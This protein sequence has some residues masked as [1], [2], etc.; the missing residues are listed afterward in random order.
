MG[1]H[2]KSRWWYWAVLVAGLAIALAVHFGR[3]AES[4]G[5]PA[6]LAELLQLSPDRLSQVPLG[7]M[8]L[9]CASSLGTANEPDPE[10]C[11]ASIGIWAEHVRSETERHSY[12]FERDPAQ[13]ENSKG[14]FRMLMLA[15]VLAEDHRAA[16]STWRRPKTNFLSVTRT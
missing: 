11:M 16:S 3:N 12:R 5:Q 4:D 13:F 14:F 6:T 7:R 2:Q 10:Q 15:V 9:L 8:D 1:K